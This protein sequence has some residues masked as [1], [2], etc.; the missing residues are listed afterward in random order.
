MINQQPTYLSQGINYL[1]FLSQQLGDLAGKTTLAHELIQNADDAKDDAGRLTATRITFDITDAAL[2]V[3]NDAVFRELDFD[4]MSNV[5]SGSKRSESGDRTTGAFGVGFISVYQITDRPEIH[6]AGRRWILRPEYPEDKR[7]EVWNDTSIISDIGTK[8]RL[9]W[10][11]EESE[12]RKALKVPPVNKDYIEALVDE[13]AEALP[14]AIL[15]LKKL[16]RIELRRDGKLVSVVTRRRH[17]TTIWINQDN[18]IR[19]WRIL[20]TDFPT[21]A[22][23]L[24]SLYGNSIDIHRSDRVRV[25]IP[26]SLI[27]DG[28][29]FAALPTEQLT[30]LPFHIDADFYP[31]SDR[32]AIEFGDVHDPR[33]EWNRAAIRAAA[34][35]VHSNLILLRDM[36]SDDA[37][38]FWG[39]L[40]QIQAV[41]QGARGD[42]RNPFGDFWKALLP[43]LEEAPIVYTES[44]KWLLPKCTRI[45]TGQ[46]EQNSV[47]AFLELGIEI[48]H[49]DLWPHR[50]LLR[51]R[52]VSVRTLSASDVYHCLKVKGYTDRPVNAPPVKSDLLEQLWQ[53]VNGVLANTQGNK[54][55]D[56]KCLLQMCSLAPGLDD[57]YWP[58]HSAYRADDEYTRGMFAP[59]MPN[60]KT[61]LTHSG[62]PL[63][64]T[65]CSVFT[66]PD[67]IATL[68]SLDMKQY[69]RR[70]DDYDPVAILQW[71]EEHKSDLTNDL[72]VQLINLSIFPSAQSLH[73]LG[74]LWLPGGFEDSMGEVDILDSKLLGSLSNFLQ[75]LGAR[76]L[77]FE[78]YAMRY[79][80]KAFAR[81]STF[82]IETKRNLLTTLEMHIGKIRDN[83]QLRDKLSAVWL[84]ECEADRFKQPN[85]AYFRTDNVYKALGEK[86]HYAFIPNKSERRRDLYHWLGVQSQPRIMDMLQNIERVTRTKPTLGA[87]GTVVQMLEA[88]RIRWQE[89][90]EHQDSIRLYFESFKSKAWLPA[91]GDSGMWYTPD[92]LFAAYNKDLFA[93]QGKFLDVPIGVQRNINDFLDWL[94]VNLS[95]QPFRVIRHLL[96]CSKLDQKPP[97]DIYRWMNQNA[98]PKD[99]RELKDT[100]C[101]WIPGKAKYLRPN[102]V[103]WGRHPFGRFR[104][105]LDS[106]LRSYQNLLE[107]LG[108]REQADISDVLDVLIDVSEEVGS[109]M[110]ETEDKSVTMQCWVMLSD[111][112][113]NEELKEKS[114]TTKLQDVRCVPTE[115]GLLQRPSWMFFEDRSGL[116]DKFSG[117][118]GQNCIPRTE[119]AW[120]AMEAAGVRPVSAVVQGYVSDVVNPRVDHDIAERVMDRIDLIRTIL[121]EA[122]AASQE[123]D[124]MSILN[125]MQFIQVDTL[126]MQWRLQA[127]NRKWPDSTPEPASAHWDCGRLMFYF[128]NH[129]GSFPWSAIARELALALAPNEN[130]ASIS[131]GLKAVLEVGTAKDAV[132]Q[133]NDLG[134]ASV[135]SFDPGSTKEAVAAS[136][137][138]DESEMNDYVQNWSDFSNDSGD[139]HSSDRADDTEDS[140]ARLF[141]DVQTTTPSSAGDNPFVLPVGSSTTSQ[142]ARVQTA[143]VSNV[144]KFESH[145]LKLVQKNELGPDGKA[146]EVEFRSMVEGD[147]GKRCQICSRTF[148]KPS[149]DWLV[150]VVHV[151]PPIKDHRANHFG[152][153]L[154]LCGWHFN[155]LQYGQW[156]LLDPNSG[157]P[158]EDMDGV[159]GWE[160]MREFILTRVP[161]TD[162]FDNQ[163]VGLPIQFSNVYQEWLSEPV[164]IVEEI[165][166]SIPHWNFLCEL[167]NE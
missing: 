65:L 155:L 13:L 74:E 79:V 143:R 21:K 102:Q 1:G 29:L 41:D 83:N 101:L 105:Q 12:V 123:E 16:E 61:F 51:Q 25:A 116:V 66:V 167:L 120:T 136:L 124:H 34:S 159:R 127:F 147:Y 86:A 161:T 118:L 154:G 132:T 30:R 109:S 157:Q 43:S 17:D 158:F 117:P 3:S 23:N 10:A 77:T 71:F 50:N 150:N 125:D 103:F 20:E 156:A 6:S 59:L 162:D 130:P 35:A 11:F 67:A 91:E 54:F 72:R 75:D 7:I 140:F 114:L 56:A 134:I 78:D 57:C 52:E 111:A 87:R 131:P 104:V 126:T 42:L 110:L 27:D 32:K 24:K 137:G 142:Q 8:F 112:L 68:A 39:V 31:A 85:E 115:M 69:G 58:C 152:D 38:T 44:G 55:W 28:L 108:V 22:K 133:L 70:A 106:R 53:G 81:E 146:L 26:D 19:C 98:E 92:K 84:V 95:P 15:F 88:L 129:N 49:R 107:G 94:G 47:G 36:Y 89:L 163:Y 14:R 76:P 160:R 96:A 145:I 164:P 148:A 122:T 93:S 4:R 165:R 63:L 37:A 166:Y 141:H 5:A 119:R 100:E 48:V 135:R 149:G 80:P 151:V 153:L 139:D 144:G 82:D 45:P 62:V 33:S 40:G 18:D 46:Q 138:D 64:E 97:N 90:N 9:P 2:I 99:L 60:D 128:A 113:K 73:P 121:V